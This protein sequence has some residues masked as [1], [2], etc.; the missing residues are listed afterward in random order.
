[1]SDSTLKTYKSI[2][3]WCDYEDLYTRIIRNEINSGDIAVE[4]GTW[5][6]RSAAFF[7]SK[8]IEE[9]KNI[10]F[11]CVDLWGGKQDDEYMDKIVSENGG[12]ILHLFEQNMK[13]CGYQN[14]YKK[15]VG[16]SAASANHFKDKSIAFCFVDANHHYEPAKKDIMAWMP[17]MKKGGYMAGHDIDR[18]SVV[19][20]VRECFG[21]K[22]QKISERCWICRID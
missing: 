13:N 15:I 14:E 5:M 17:K 6:G 4:V 11:Y 2:Q 3:G 16:D 20:A 10:E 7:V 1:M 12:S 8:M 18:D 21:N 19:R 22:W 9:K